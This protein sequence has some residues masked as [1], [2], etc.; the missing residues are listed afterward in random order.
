[1]LTFCTVVAIYLQTTYSLPPSLS[2]FELSDSALSARWTTNRVVPGQG[3]TARYCIKQSQLLGTSYT[4]KCELL[5]TQGQRVLHVNQPIHQMRASFPTD[6]WQTFM[7]QLPTSLEPGNYRIAMHL[8]SPY[9]KVKLQEKQ[10]ITVEPMKLAFA[11]CAFS[12]DMPGRIAA[13]PQQLQI[14]QPVL[15]RFAIVGLSI[16][17]KQCHYRCTLEV[18][19]AEGQPLY[20]VKLADAHPTA[21]LLPGQSTS[22]GMGYFTNVMTTPGK[23]RY[24]IKVIDMVS[25]NVAVK[26]IAVEFHAPVADVPAV[27]SSK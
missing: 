12:Y 6:N 10:T 2:V 16:Q 27:V 8:Q 17:E 26:E 21:T 18:L 3:I 4:M 7:M 19:N 1:M 24:R 22:G 14:L 5:N 20:E 15:L 11:H 23:Y 25:W 9:C 13:A